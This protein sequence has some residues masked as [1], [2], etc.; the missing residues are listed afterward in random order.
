MK[1]AALPQKLRDNYTWQLRPPFAEIFDSKPWWTQA[2]DAAIDS[3]AALYE[4]ARRHP[5]VGALRTKFLTSNWHGQELGPPLAGRAFRRMADAAFKDVGDQH[6]AIHCL[7]LIGLKAWISLDLK[8]REFW[9]MSAGKLKGVDCRDR[10]A[11]CVG[12]ISDGLNELILASVSRLNLPNGSLQFHV[13][14]TRGD[15]PARVAAANPHLADAA[16][17]RIAAEFQKNPPRASELEAVIARNAGAAFRNGEF[18]FTLAP[19]L[20]HERAVA[21]FAEAYRAEQ[22]EA[23]LEPQRG[24]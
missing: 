1:R 17:K 19:D 9:E 24:R 12:L 11:Q 7:C 18:I 4:L 5:R 8:D 3:V 14:A 22:A 15:T 23:G 20:T 10:G 21:I 13:E 16:T 2:R 6:A